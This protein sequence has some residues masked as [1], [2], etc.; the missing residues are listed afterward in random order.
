MWVI[1]HQ[2]AIKISIFNWEAL[3]PEDLA[4]LDLH[5]FHHLR[6]HV[7][8]VIELVGVMLAV[9]I[10]TLHSVTNLRRYCSEGLRHVK[11]HFISE[12][13]FACRSH[14][15]HIGS[16]ETLVIIDWGY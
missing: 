1:E 9:D 7:R 3:W 8:I 11:E 12:V 6:L 10:A 14:D 5:A 4:Q 13:L 16:V 2:R 15:A